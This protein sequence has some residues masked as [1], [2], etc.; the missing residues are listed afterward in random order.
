[1]DRTFSQMIARSISLQD[2]NTKVYVVVGPCRS[3]TTAFLRVFSEVG[4]QSWYQPIKAVIRGQMRNESF[5]FQIPALPSVM[6]KDTFGP[7]SVEES[8][9]NPIEILLEA[10]ATADNLHLLTVSR[11]PV[12]TACSWIRIN[13]QVGAD[14][15]AAALAYLAMGYRN[16][17]RLAAYATDH[18][19][20][21]TPFA[22]ELLRD[23]D[24]ALIRTLLASRLGISQP[25]KGMNWRDLPPVE[26][27]NHLIK[28]VEQGRR[29]NVPDLHSKLNRSAGLVYYSKS[30]DELAQYLDAS[31][32]SALTDEG[33]FECHRAH[34]SMSSA[35]FGLSIRH[36]AIAKEYGLGVVE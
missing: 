6:L 30:T 8:C 13:K 10:G 4:I 12:A 24:P 17:L 31:H 23:H 33:V 5:A 14:A 19:V 18:H 20:A 29:Y 16:L 11:D 15:S 9:F 27:A 1:M 32:I 3:G 34:Q 26:S 36:T 7:F 35:A 28:Y 21:H 22:Y 2:R 25:V